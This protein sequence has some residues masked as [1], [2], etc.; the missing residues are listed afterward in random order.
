MSTL[1]K[2]ISEILSG[3][4]ENNEQ[5]GNLEE[6]SRADIVLFMY[7]PVSSVNVDR[8]LLDVQDIADGQPSEI[9]ILKSVKRTARLG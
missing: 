7:L 8:L 3:K 5:N 9:Q 4:E 6:L 2:N 1:K